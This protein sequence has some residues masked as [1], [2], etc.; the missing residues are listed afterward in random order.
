M[1]FVAATVVLSCFPAALLADAADVAEP[2]SGV[3]FASHLGEMSLLGV[4]LR[5]KTFLHVKV[6]AVGLYVADAALSGPLASFKGKTSS[7]G[8]ARAIV[9][10]DFEKQIVMTFTRDLSS[11][12]IQDGFRE[13]L[14]GADAQK[15]DLFVGYFPDVKVG[16]Q[17]VLHWTGSALEVQVAGL[18]K[19]PIADRAF[20]AKLF[21]VWLGDAPVQDDIKAGLVARAGERVR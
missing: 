17:A 21:G 8:F 19:P 3:T 6:Y 7:P 5:T 12:Q 20:A 10:G 18:G 11:S 9:D 13:S 1:R 14:K 4:G 2:K 16:Q 15:I